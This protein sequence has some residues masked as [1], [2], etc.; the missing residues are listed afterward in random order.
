MWRN[1]LLCMLSITCLIKTLLKNNR[2]WSDTEIAPFEFSYSKYRRLQK[3]EGEKESHHIYLLWWK[4]K[5]TAVSTGYGFTVLSS[6]LLL[7]SQETCLSTIVHGSLQCTFYLCGNKHYVFNFKYDL[8]LT[9]ILLSVQKED[10]K[11]QRGKK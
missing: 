2:N 7:I 11:L 5:I 4:E 6:I 10:T 3:E 8:P 1:A 9:S